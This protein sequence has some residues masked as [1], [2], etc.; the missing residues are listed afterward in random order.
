VPER[1]VRM[2]IGRLQFRSDGYCVDVPEAG[3][4]VVTATSLRIQPSVLHSRYS[5]PSPPA[6]AAYSMR[7]FHKMS[8][9]YCALIDS[10]YSISFA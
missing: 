4:G 7:F 1:V 2:N 9:A 10:L 3:G 6:P 8:R 5:S